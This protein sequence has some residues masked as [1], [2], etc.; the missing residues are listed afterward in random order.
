MLI[1]V[2]ML[3][4]LGLGVPIFSLLFGFLNEGTTGWGWV[5]VIVVSVASIVGAVVIYVVARLQRRPEE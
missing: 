4:I 5:A 1:P 2:L 3:F